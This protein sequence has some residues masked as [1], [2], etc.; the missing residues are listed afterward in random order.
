MHVCHVC[1]F[2]CYIIITFSVVFINIIS[3]RRIQ[4]VVVVVVVVGVGVVSLL[5]FQIPSPSS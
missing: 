5:S 1:L 2:D 3:I 4:P